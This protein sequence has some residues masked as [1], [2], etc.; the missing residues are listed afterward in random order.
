MPQNSS[1]A[2][3]VTVGDTKLL[4]VPGNEM[5]RDRNLPLES[6]VSWF[7]CFVNMGELLYTYMIDNTTQGVSAFQQGYPLLPTPAQ[8][9]QG[10]ST[11]AQL[12]EVHPLLPTPVKL[13]KQ[14]SPL[15][16]PP[17]HPPGLLPASPELQQGSLLPVSPPRQ[18]GHPSSAF[19][20]RSSP[21][22]SVPPQSADLSP[23]VAEVLQY[24]SAVQSPHGQQPNYSLPVAP[25]S[26]SSQMPTQMLHY[27]NTA[28]QS[29]YPQSQTSYMQAPAKL[30]AQSSSS[31]SSSSQI[32]ITGT[33]QHNY[34][35]FRTPNLPGSSRSRVPN[36]GQPY[37][38]NVQGL[39]GYGGGH[40][41]G[42]EQSS[43]RNHQAR[44]APN[45]QSYQP[46]GTSHFQASHSTQQMNYAPGSNY[47]QALIGAAYTNTHS[48]APVHG[49]PGQSAGYFPPSSTPLQQ[50]ALPH[51]H[52]HANPVPPSGAKQTI[53]TRSRKRK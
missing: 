23:S 41:K 19:S 47:P 10:Q 14:G 17:S 52:P 21:F 30:L 8:L 50:Q 36:L 5:R 16:I 6:K 24:H 9:Q 35:D 33:P 29:P 37:Y 26:N 51:A 38:Q 46:Y 3:T 48:Q 11:S 39:Q 45:Y 27:Q 2:I 28:L 13:E 49:I 18:Q 31:S 43:P 22:T 12:Q 15:L 1:F 7:Y 44:G 53:R 34:Q 32:P 20:A 42:M 40:L 4:I 25:G